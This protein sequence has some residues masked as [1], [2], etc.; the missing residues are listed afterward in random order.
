MAERRLPVRGGRTPPGRFAP[1][2]CQ[3]WYTHYIMCI[4]IYIYTHICYKLCV[5]YYIICLYISIYML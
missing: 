2:R 3:V 5:I 4:Y 1:T